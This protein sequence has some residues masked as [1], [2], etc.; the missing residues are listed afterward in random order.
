MAAIGGIGAGLVVQKVLAPE[1][2]PFPAN[3]AFVF[4]CAWACFMVSLVIV[5]FLQENPVT[6]ES[7]RQAKASSFQQ[8]LRH[9]LKTDRVFRRT[10]LARFLV[11]VEAMAASFYVVFIRESLQLTDAVIGQFTLAFILGSIAG[12]V[13]FGWL[14][15][16]YGTLRVLQ[17][18]STMQFI[19]PLLAFVVALIPA[20]V[21]VRPELAVGLLLVS[22][23]LN[24]AV[25][26]SL[27]LGYLGYVIDN[28]AE[29]YRAT[30]VGVFN[31]VNGVVSLAPVVGGVLID[32]LARTIALS[33]AYAIAFGIVTVAVGIGVVLSFRLPRVR[34]AE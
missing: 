7:L 2:L 4:L 22:V 33:A 26:H 10:I 29:R 30:Y 1:G 20:I 19:A 24:G 11:S 15:D 8:D 14:H 3:Y 12:I 21:D 13:V 34:S 23:A 28:A 18:S 27:L 6:D 9:I 5:F 32:T 16:R 25:S 31:T 17:A